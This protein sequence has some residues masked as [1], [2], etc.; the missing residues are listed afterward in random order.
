M[1]LRDFAELILTIDSL[2]GKLAAPHEEIEDTAPGSAIALPDAPARP[3]SLRF[4]IKP[5]EQMAL[6][7]EPELEDEAQRGVLLHFFANHELLATE[8]MAL[9]LLRFP[10]APSEFRQGVYETLREEQRH[11]LWYLKR[12]E[13]C[14]VM[15]GD[16]PVSGFFWKCVAPM[17][18]P[19]DYV[20]RL[21][22]TFEQ[23]NLDYSRHYAEILRR[24]GDDKSARI[25][26]R[27]YRDEI[28]HVSYGL[29]WFRK[30]KA[31]GQTD[32]EAFR[33]QLDFPLSPSRAKANGEAPFNAKGRQAA[34]LEET[35]IRELNAFERSKGRTPRI[36]WFCPDAENQMASGMEGDKASPKAAVRSLAE[37]LDILPAFLSSRDDIVLVRNQPSLEHRERLLSWGFQLPEFEV[38]GE[39]GKL[40]PDSLSRERKLAELCPWAWCPQSLEL[41]APL[42]PNLSTNQPDPAACWTEPI[43]R[44]FSKATD[45]DLLSQITEENPALS[46]IDSSALGQR[47]SSIEDLASAMAEWESQGVKEI[48]L[49]APYGASAQKNQR[50]RGEATAKWAA[51]VIEQQGCLII[52]PWLERAMD[53]SY[54]YQMEPEGLRALGFVRL[55]NDSRGQFR[56]VQCG[57]KTCEGMA[58]EVARFMNEGALEFYETILQDALEDHLR[59]SQYLGPVGVDSFVYRVGDQLRLKAISE[60][61]PRYTMGRVVWELRRRVASDRCARFELRRGGK[62]TQSDMTAESGEGTIQLN[63][64]RGASGLQA[65][66]HVSKRQTDFPK[67]P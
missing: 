7:R 3:E 16:Y 55:C 36:Y 27:I 25:L 30:W 52:E 6:P 42:A 37:D 43:R 49:K 51:G 2:E 62:V 45:L 34:G 15:F 9:V 47:I 12:M 46:Y 41:L 26:S 35:F 50:W 22:L 14:G 17:E 23:A 5:N 66:L 56:A 58:S 63:E 11:T 28:N 10:D 64:P 8:L 19:L 33:Q 48:L 61:N 18:T 38:L 29:D 13:E 32:W 39:D 1:Q 65:L 4:A 44:L 20:S 21:S 54:Q 40:A 24:S 31:P 59:Q 53:F 67:L 57:T 60:I